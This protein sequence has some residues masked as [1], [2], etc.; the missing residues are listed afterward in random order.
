M[1]KIIDFFKKHGNAISG[2]LSVVAII[3]SFGCGIMMADGT[4]VE[5]TIGNEGPTP[6]AS[7]ETASAATSDRIA[8]GG[9]TVGQDLTG[10]QAS[11]SQATAGGLVED[12]WDNQI[13]KYKPFRNPLN[14]IIRA[15]AR[16]QKITNWSIK[17]MRVGGETLEVVTTKAIAAGSTIVLKN[18]GADA[19]V[20][21]SLRPFYKCSTVFAL[22]VDGYKPG[23]KTVADGELMLFV[24]ESSK[25]GVTLQ[26]V[27]GP[28]AVEGVGGDTLD[29]YT[30]PAIPS[31]T[32][33]S[34]GATAASESQ[35]MVSPE[36]YQP[37]EHEAYVQKKLLNIVFT[38]DFEEVKKKVPFKVN[39]IKEDAI[40]KYNMRQERTYWKGV[41]ARISV[42]SADGANE[43]VYFS[44]GI[45]HQ[46]TN[47][48]AI[49]G[50]YTL[51]DLISISRLQF[52]TFAE[53]SQ[54]YGFCGSGALQK[55][56]QIDITNKGNNPGNR[57]VFTNTKD[58]DIDFTTFKSAFGTLDFVY[59][60]TLDMIHME[61][62]IVIMDISNA[63]RYLKISS[64]DTTN[65]MSKG[66]GEI[67]DAK[68]FIHEEADCLQL[69]GYNSIIVGPSSVIYNIKETDYMNKI[70]SASVLP[71]A[72]K[73]TAKT[74]STIGTLVSLTAD[75]TVG[76]TTYE[77]GKVYEAASVA[78]GVVTWTE[79]AGTI[80]AA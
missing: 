24:V 9:H 76:T 18:T 15:K 27:N 52:T 12:E 6:G 41:Q 63:V 65:D 19:N 44:E 56:L 21:G 2:I 34:C 26:A 30:V 51:N 45:L 17:H 7:T 35:L 47:S 67:R 75:C 74:A 49:D 68:R 70:I 13:I 57:D 25:T 69:R 80:V 20:K 5:P 16:T 53:S 33:L 43:L 66:S 71:D 60:Q 77:A 23:S 14:S 58:L 40:Y 32:I 61:D 48:Y 38:K 79:Y 4:A 22:G 8:P 39:D 72:S 10:T 29:D 55:L 42:Q 28:A 37:R 1:T 78:D 54:S 46:I 11:S 73:V 62:C 3:L 36:N 59:D 31:G 64:K 50:V